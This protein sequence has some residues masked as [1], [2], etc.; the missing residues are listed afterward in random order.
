MKE[1][2]EF[3]TPIIGGVLLMSLGALIALFLL[4]LVVRNKH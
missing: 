3:V 1:F 4:W 2:A